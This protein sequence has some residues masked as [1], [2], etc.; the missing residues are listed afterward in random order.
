ML[1][2]DTSSP[3]CTTT[4]VLYSPLVLQD[5]LARTVYTVTECFWT[6]PFISTQRCPCHCL[7][8]QLQVNKSV[9]CDIRLSCK[10]VI[11]LLLNS[12]L[13]S[14]STT[15]YQNAISVVYNVMSLVKHILVWTISG[16]IGSLWGN[17]TCYF[18][19]LPDPTQNHAIGCFCLKRS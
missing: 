9:W 4:F 14:K 8:K 1:L 18:I 5:G 17:C 19:R 16:C 12:L 13:P 2:I 10:N 15:D 3:A 7:Q 6:C 11:L